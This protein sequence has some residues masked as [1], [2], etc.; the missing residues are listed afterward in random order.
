MA[1]NDE[2]EFELILG[3]RQLVSVF[4]IVVILLGAFFSMGYLVGR[5]ATTTAVVAADT[6]RPESTP[7]PIVVESPPPVANPV[8]AVVEKPSPAPVKQEA[9]KKQE[10]R[11]EPAPVKA[12]AEEPRAGQT[13]L[14]V[15]ATTRPD[16]EIVAESLAKKGFRTNVVPGPSAALF[17]VVVG[18]VGN[19]ADLAETRVKLEAAGFKPYVRRY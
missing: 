13:F 9:P 18:P 6:T 4:L 19:A 10:V 3:N 14:Q 15:V 12:G 17:R 8:P 7:K 5:S 2:G 1:K 16:A 11:P